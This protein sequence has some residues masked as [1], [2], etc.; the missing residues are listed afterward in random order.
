[1]IV[2]DS[3]VLIDFL[4]GAEPVAGRMAIEIGTGRLCTT[5][6]SAFEIRS[7]SRGRRQADAIERLLDALQVLPIDHEAARRAAEVRCA[8][9][10]EGKPIGLA[11]YLV[12]GVCLSLGAML[13]TRNRREFGRVPGLS[14]AELSLADDD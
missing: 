10:K 1:M 5:A 9:E 2:A 13:L 14:L 7:G 11:D 6:M 12:A 8:L 3:D 4:R